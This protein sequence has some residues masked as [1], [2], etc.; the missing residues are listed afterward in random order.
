M[1][2]WGELYSKLQ[3]EQVWT[4]LGR[5]CPVQGG[6]RTLCIG[7]GCRAMYSDPLT[8]LPWQNDS[9]ADRQNWKHYLPS[10]SLAGS[11][12]S[13]DSKP[14]QQQM[15]WEWSDRNPK[16]GEL[17]T[18]TNNNEIIFVLDFTTFVHN[19]IFLGWKCQ[20]LTNRLNFSGKINRLKISLQN[21]YFYCFGQFCVF[22]LY[23]W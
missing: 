1:S 4:Y 21:D 3:V 20:G 11:N 5:W 17:T 22:L 7:R 9:L 15:F 16:G 6:A 10:V 23:F 12:T 13:K 2:G 18:A 8:L 19:T 14:L